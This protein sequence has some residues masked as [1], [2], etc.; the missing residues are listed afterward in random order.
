[1]LSTNLN[2]YQVHPINY[3]VPSSISLPYHSLKQ[4]Q[5]T[6]AAVVLN[7]AVWIPVTPQGCPVPSNHLAPIKNQFADYSHSLRSSRFYKQK[8]QTK[9]NFQQAHPPFFYNKKN[10]N[11]GVDT[12]S[13][14]VKKKFTALHGTASVIA[15]TVER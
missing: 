15:K 13:I 1:M 14:L 4:Q 7:S 5:Q 2:E 12:N 6:A 3:R 11:Q 9:N 10:K 8:F